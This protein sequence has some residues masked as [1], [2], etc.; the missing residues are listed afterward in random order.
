MAAELERESV[1][2]KSRIVRI[3]SVS[4]E[5]I[6]D[7]IHVHIHPLIGGTISAIYVDFLNP[8]LTLFFPKLYSEKRQR[9]APS[10]AGL[11]DTSGSVSDMSKIV[12]KSDNI[13]EV[14][15]QTDADSAQDHEIAS[16]NS[17]PKT[18]P[19]LDVTPQKLAHPQPPM[20]APALKPSLPHPF[21]QSSQ[22]HKFDSRKQSVS[23][24]PATR[25]TSPVTT[26]APTVERKI[27]GGSLE[28]LLA[29][30]Q[31]TPPMTGGSAG[32]AGLEN[33]A[34]SANTTGNAKLPHVLAYLP[35]SPRGPA[36][37]IK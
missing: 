33:G 28:N 7:Q 22:L 27:S 20:S 5:I 3:A 26:K 1:V 8:N 25:A 15:E 9:I 37:P 12:D 35:S 14:S 18:A 21:L 29:A 24:A 4:I 32:S 17:G 36:S 30:S 16:P 31:F 13:L 11:V 23:S 34:A 6:L 10:S 2:D 19:S